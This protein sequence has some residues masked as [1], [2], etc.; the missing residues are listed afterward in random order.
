M[1]SRWQR[2]KTAI[3]AGATYLELDPSAGMGGWVVAEAVSVVNAD[4]EGARQTQGLLE[5]KA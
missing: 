5:G 2:Y 3:D 4:A 1:L